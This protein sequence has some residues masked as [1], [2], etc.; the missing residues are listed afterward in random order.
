LLRGVPD[1]LKK[2]LNI[3]VTPFSLN[4][5]MGNEFF[6]VQVEYIKYGDLE[7]AIVVTC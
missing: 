6:E 5:R 1:H 4:F 7:I 3:D 2:L